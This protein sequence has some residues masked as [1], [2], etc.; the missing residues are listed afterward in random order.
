MIKR[1]LR[2]KLTPPV[3]RN[4]EKNTNCTL[5]GGSISTHNISL[6]MYLGQ[7]FGEKEKEIERVEVQPETLDFYLFHFLFSIFH[8]RFRFRFNFSFPH[9]ILSPKTALVSPCEKIT[10]YRLHRQQ[11]KERYDEISPQNQP[12][13]KK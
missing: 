12:R 11:V 6:R 1:T 3:S 5:L 8:F 7:G 13:K 2:F 9:Q 10:T 4:K